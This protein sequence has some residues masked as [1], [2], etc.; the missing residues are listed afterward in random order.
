[1]SEG[2]F[3][4][5]NDLL[6]P[7]LTATA[8]AEEGA[9]IDAIYVCPHGWNDQCSCRKP[10]PGMLFQAQRDFDLDLS[11]TCFIGDD[12]RDIEA[13]LAA[14]TPTV[15][16]DGEWPLIRIVKERLLASVRT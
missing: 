8:L 11:R 1:M 13:G 2:P 16:V 5:G 14:G 3:F 6:P 9:V 10:K 7:T 4:D 15:K 12:D